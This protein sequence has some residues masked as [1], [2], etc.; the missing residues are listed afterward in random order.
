MHLIIGASAQEL[1]AIQRLAEL[2]PTKPIICFNLKL[3]TLRGDLGLP[4]F[5]PRDV[6][7]SFLSKCAPAPPLRRPV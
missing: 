5:P 2:E 1:P 4:A 7:H 3:D 6:H